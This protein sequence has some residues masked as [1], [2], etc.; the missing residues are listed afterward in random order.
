MGL[1]LLKFEPFL[2]LVYFIYIIY[3]QQW[4]IHKK[5]LKKK[6]IINLMARKM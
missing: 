4:N 2:K 5:R 1:R 3:I 6:E